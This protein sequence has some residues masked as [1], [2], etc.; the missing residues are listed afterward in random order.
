M[1]SNGSSIQQKEGTIQLTPEKD[2][3][4]SGFK[5]HKNGL[6]AIGTPSFEQ[7]QECGDFIKKSNGAVHFWIGDWLNYGERTWGEM[8]SQALDETSFEYGTLRNDKYISDKMQLSLRND[9]LTFGHAQILVSLPDKEK[10]F[11]VNELSKQP[12]P[13][14]ELRERIKEKRKLELPS[15]TTPKTKYETIV[16]D[17]PWPVEFMQLQMRPNQVIMPYPTMTIDELKAFTLVKDIADENCNL[18]IWTTHTYLPDTFSILEA[19]GFK[20]HVC[21]TWNKTNGRSLFGF[22]RMTEFVVYAHKGNITVNQRGEF[23]DTIF[24]EKLREHSRKPDVFYEMIKKNTPDQRRIDI[25][26]R[27]KRDG[28]DQWGNEEGKF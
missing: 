15:P 14:R 27:E 22:N 4:Y 19:W 17:P 6:Q 21:L 7:W 10:M 28:F 11:W 16:I 3:I 18:F 13:I 24:T 9:N 12:M 2:I 8:Y 20:Y 23:I 1:I 5:L 25:F 26:S